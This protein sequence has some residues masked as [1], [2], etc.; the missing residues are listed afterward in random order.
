MKRHYLFLMRS[1]VAGELYL[2]GDRAELDSNQMAGL[3]AMG[4]VEEIQAP[5]IT[6]T[7]QIVASVE[8]AEP[9]AI[10][11]I[12]SVE[13]VASIEVSDTAETVT[14]TPN[15]N[16]GKLTKAELNAE[17]DKR[18]IAHDAKATNEVL[19]ALLVADDSAKTQG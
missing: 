2:K 3:V 19:Q 14:S 4:A 9:V 12:E 1:Y 13:P 6:A 8:S 11:P 15:A 17:L 16:Y 5:I 18:G 10:A 7:A